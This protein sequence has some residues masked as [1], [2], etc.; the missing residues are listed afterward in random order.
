MIAQF[1]RALRD[2][3]EVRKGFL[4]K[5]AARVA[6]F[7]RKFDR[8]YDPPRH[9]VAWAE[10]VNLARRQGAI[11][12][13]PPPPKTVLRRVELPGSDPALNKHLGIATEG[14]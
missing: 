4:R 5:I 11:D 2:N 1:D 3:P 14:D 10:L 8:D 12:P 7:E 6:R 9:I 13:E